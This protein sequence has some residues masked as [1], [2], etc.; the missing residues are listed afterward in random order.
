MCVYDILSIYVFILKIEGGIVD[1]IGRKIAKKS[2]CLLG[3]IHVVVSLTII[4]TFYYFHI[5]KNVLKR[6]FQFFYSESFIQQLPCKKQTAIEKIQAWSY[7]INLEIMC[8]L[9]AAINSKENLR[10]EYRVLLQLSLLTFICD[11]LVISVCLSSYETN[12][13]QSIVSVVPS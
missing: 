8:Y 13:P 12:L 10:R 2:F 6:T 7:H 5:S 4:M 11:P 9:D 1:V 3:F